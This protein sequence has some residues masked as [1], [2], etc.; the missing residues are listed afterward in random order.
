[1]DLE[2][3]V[4][5]IKMRIE[6]FKRT[7]ELKTDPLVTIKLF[8]KKDDHESDSEK[9]REKLRQNEVKKVDPLFQHP[10]SDKIISIF[11]RFSY[12]IEGG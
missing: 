7:Y 6:K 11:R 2:D 4:S 9:L 1:M 10:V 12:L 8:E 3:R 5:F